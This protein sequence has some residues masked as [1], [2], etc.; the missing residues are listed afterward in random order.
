MNTQAVM[1]MRPGPVAMRTSPTAPASAMTPKDIINIVRKRIWLVV[2]VTALCT[3]AS[4]VLWY[5]IRS[6]YPQYTSVAFIRVKMP[7]QQGILATTGLMP[8]VQVIELATQ[9]KA[10][11][12][13]NEVFLSSVLERSTVQRTK[14]FERYKD[15][16]AKLLE[17]MKDSFSAS[18][19]RN[20]EFVVVGMEAGSPDE[21]QTILNEALD[22][23]SQAMDEEATGDLRNLRKALT[24]GQ[25]QLEGELRAKRERLAVLSREAKVPGWERGRT[26]VSDELTAWSQ[27]KL[28]L[29]A[30]ERDL[31]LERDRVAAE[32]GQGASQTVQSAVSQHPMVQG[33]RNR[34]SG[35]QEELD[36]LTRNSGFGQ[37]HRQ[38]QEVKARIASNESQLGNMEQNLTSMYAA[39]EVV[40]LE[41]QLE[42][43]QQQLAGATGTYE[44]LSARQRQLDEKLIEYTMVQGEVEQLSRHLERY[45]E[46]LSE[47]RA[48][49]QDKSRVSAE[50]AIRANRPLQ[51]SFPILFVFLSAGLVLGVVLS[52]GLCFLLEF[53]DDSVKSPT[54][55]QRY[56]SVPNLGM[57]PMY[58]ED[59]AKEIALGKV[60]SLKP[61][62]M[63]SEF[64]R[65]IKTSLA[66]SAP[67]EELKT[68]LVTSCAGGCGK[69]VTASNLAIAFASDGER[70]LLIDTNFRRPALR[71]LFGINTGQG[72]S[73]LLVGR[74]A[75]DDVI[76]ASGVSGLDVIT[77][78]PV[79]PNPANLFNGQALRD[80]LATQRER[81]DRVILDGAPALVV[82]DARILSGRVDGT[83]ITVR[84]SGTGRGVVLRLIRELRASKAKILGV[85]LNAV[86]PRRGGY[87]RESYERY[88][89]YMRA[90][91]GIAVTSDADRAKETE[92]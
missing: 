37:N 48:A 73:D 47:T 13:Q 88:D 74:V 72:L 25:K 44:E 39:S 24:E 28:Y 79:P 92:S 19:R 53:L 31:L 85:L 43:V 82:T 77:S 50:V 18:P 65:Q 60:V 55:V 76:H 80:L 56:L 4:V 83:I 41:Q 64:Y 20:S 68:M 21:A 1:P 70:V 8:Q 23:F 30:L 12:L 81:Y 63:I 14:W 15:D 33:F 45:E 58:M 38:V 54:D 2:L 27:E 7:V 69:T 42:T 3:V 29:R 51:I 67:A 17:S 84:A 40:G 36:G 90:P 71:E 46:R 49:E 89:E 91:S 78:G 57:V 9:N 22:V 87:F 6:Y 35:L 52:L 11:Y 59:D 5:V 26:V 61:Q 75:A 34:I 62:S 10:L 32:A 86:E 66:F 16:P